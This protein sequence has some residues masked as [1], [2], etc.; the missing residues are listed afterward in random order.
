[1][2]IEKTLNAA[3]ALRMTADCSFHVTRASRNCQSARTKSAEKKSS[4]PPL[5]RFVAT[6]HNVRRENPFAC[7]QTFLVRFL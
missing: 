4:G 1:V 5:K 7:I 6:R 3:N 2:D